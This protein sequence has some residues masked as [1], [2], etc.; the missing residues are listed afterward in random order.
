ME[1]S[2][3]NVP[4]RIYRFQQI[5]TDDTRGIP[6]YAVTQEAPRKNVAGG[7]KIIDKPLHAYKDRTMPTGSV[8]SINP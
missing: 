4:D 8:S 6:I 1:S 3:Q 7:V 5:S 2:L